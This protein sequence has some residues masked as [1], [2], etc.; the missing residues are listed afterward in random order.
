MGTGRH[1]KYGV[2]VVSPVE[3]EHAHAREH[4]QIRR[5]ELTET[6]VQE[7]TGTL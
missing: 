1:G 3:M 2:N 4:V 7:V 6:N 5:L